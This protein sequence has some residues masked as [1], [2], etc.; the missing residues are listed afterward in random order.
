MQ[1][2]EVANASAGQALAGQATE[3]AFG[4]VQPTTVLGRMDPGD[5]SHELP[6][7]FGRERFI[8]GP[9]RVRI[10]VIGNQRDLRTLG[11]SRVEQMSDFESPIDLR[12]TRTRRGL[13]ES[14]QRFG[15]HEDARR[16]LAFVFVID[17]LGMILSRFDRYAGLADE[18]NRLFVHAQHR[19][20]RIVGFFIGFQ[21]FL[22]VGDELAIGLGRNHPVLDL[23]LRQAVFV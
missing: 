8:E 4:D 10:Q 5:L 18:L 12:S 19:T 1:E 13:P 3:F 17:S 21:H 16:S 9:F 22:H 20:L 15:K 2:F 23:T 14:G 6:S 7:L 11:I